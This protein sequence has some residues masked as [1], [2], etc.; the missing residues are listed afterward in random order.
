MSVRHHPQ[1]STPGNP[2]GHCPFGQTVVLGYYDGPTAGLTRCP[3]CARAYRFDLLDWD[4]EQDVRIFSIAPVPLD[5]F[6]AVLK[7]CPQSAEP[8]QAIWVPRWEFASE[9]QQEAANAAIERALN[10]A[11]PVEAAVAVADGLG[12]ILAERRIGATDL[13]EV[14]D[15][16]EFLGLPRRRSTA[17]E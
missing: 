14:K 2:Q 11:E 13:A 1:S 7:A 10:R 15:W 4:D 3:E 5:A 6:D 12:R 9:S 16:F 17:D 8:K